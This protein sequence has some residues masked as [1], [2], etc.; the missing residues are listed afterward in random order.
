[1]LR[2]PVLSRGP[3][4][5]VGKVFDNGS[6]GPRPSDRRCSCGSVLPWHSFTWA[7]PK[8]HF[9]GLHQAAVDRFRPRINSRDGVPVNTND[10]CHCVARLEMTLTSHSIRSTSTAGTCGRVVGIGLFFRQRPLSQLP[11]QARI[12]SSAVLAEHGEEVLR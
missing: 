5:S 7:V 12:G 1:M 10:V 11:G 4:G 8:D 2:C 9:T 3:T 6:C